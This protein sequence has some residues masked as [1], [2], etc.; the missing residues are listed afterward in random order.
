[1]G[2]VLPSCEKAMEPFEHDTEGERGP[3][4]ELRLE[5]WDVDMERRLIQEWRRV[6]RLGCG[7][8][9]SPMPRS[10]EGARSVSV[11]LLKLGGGR[12]FSTVIARDLLMLVRCDLASY[13]QRVARGVD[14]EDGS[15]SGEELMA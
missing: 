14:E 4:L 11:K 3:G 15:A 5:W 8:T 12:A 10:L 13:A 1:M 6:A 2:A 9:S 7:S